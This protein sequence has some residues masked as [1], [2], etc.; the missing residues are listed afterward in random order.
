MCAQEL[1]I[2]A[3]KYAKGGSGP[4]ASEKQACPEHDAEADKQ[5]YSYR[6][7]ERHAMHVHRWFFSDKLG[8]LDQGLYEDGWKVRG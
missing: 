7:T 3:D 4:D 8:S 5:T 6:R 2:Q 1:R